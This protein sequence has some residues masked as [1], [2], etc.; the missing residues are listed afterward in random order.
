M[1]GH[2]GLIVLVVAPAPALA[3]PVVSPTAETSAAVARTEVRL[4]PCAD[5][6][7]AAWNRRLDTYAWD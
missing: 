1:K 5:L 7:Q 3:A 2:L 6:S 4:L